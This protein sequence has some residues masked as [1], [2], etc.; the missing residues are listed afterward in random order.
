MS[1]RPDQVLTRQQL[2]DAFAE[3][4]IQQG[5]AVILHS[6]FKSLGTVDGGPNTVIDALLDAVGPHGHL[7]VPTFTYSLPMWHVEPF[8]PKTSKARVGVIP[9]VLRQRTDAHRSFHPTHSVAVIGPHAEDII[10]NH[11][12]ATPLGA[13]CPFDRM[14][15]FDAKILML[16]T[17]QDTN[18]SLH[19][20]EVLAGLPYVRV[21]F[22]EGQDFEIAWFINED[23]QVEYTQIFEV[24]GCSRGFR[25]VEEPLR[26]VGVLRDVRVGPSVSQLLRLNDLVNAMKELLHADPTML[27]CTHNDCGIC[28]KRRR[29]MAKQ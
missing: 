8:D 14:R 2:A 15:K 27:L 10:R 16:G 3:I 29:F 1:N 22:T 25:V 18:S 12:H 17:F 7:L 26:Q 21:A 19:L 6:S 13:D 20:C 4:G 5:D 24:P 11:L 9:D 23:G 28:P